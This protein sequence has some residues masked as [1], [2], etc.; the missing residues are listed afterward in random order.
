MHHR[1]TYFSHCYAYPFASY[2]MTLPDFEHLQGGK[3]L[4]SN[5]P[6]LHPHCSLK[7]GRQTTGLIPFAFK[8][9][10]SAPFNSTKAF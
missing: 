3:A 8:N 6:E 5:L 1:Q 4:P 9:F 7:A 10:P 2:L